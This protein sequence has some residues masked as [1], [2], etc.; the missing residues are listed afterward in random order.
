[1]PQETDV[2]ER[3][4]HPAVE[5]EVSKIIGSGEVGFQVA[6][7]SGN[8]LVIN[9]WA[10]QTAADGGEVTGE[11][12]FPV[13]SVSKAVVAT[14]VHVQAEQGYLDYDA[15][16]ARYWPE[17]AAHDKDP[18][19]VRHVLSHRAGIPAM[20][21]GISPETMCDWSAVIELLADM[22]PL[23]PAGAHS[24]YLSMTFGWLLGEV[25]RRT[26]PQ[27]RPF[28]QFVAEEVC[29]PLAMDSCFIG[30]PPAEMHRVATLSSSFR[31]Q[32]PAPRDP[33]QPVPLSARAIPPQLSLG[34]AVFN[35]P[36]VQEAGIPAVGGISNAASMARLFA[37]LAGYGVLGDARLLSAERVRS[38]LTPRPGHL[39]I[40]EVYGKPF[41][42]GIGGYWV[43]APGL[44]DPESEQHPILA[45][46][47]AGGSIA[48]ADLETGTSV[49]VCHNHM[50]AGQ[51]RA[52]ADAVRL[53]L[54][55]SK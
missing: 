6:A 4:T 18:I 42:V 45:H 52:L 35:R 13:F 2:A 26:D 36:D 22:K 11:T 5:A 48:W 28:S 12:I 32:P 55:E 7:M 49:A 41:P 17:F 3:L 24:T 47:G 16:L 19:T 34:P 20:P 54:D 50:T 29:A 40:D 38:F 14:A 21:D 46:T 30:V 15:P 23:Y 51:Y 25:V 43:T 53:A 33:S 1:M 10:G 8:Q 9:T 44:L 27:Q 31:G 39:E 37:M